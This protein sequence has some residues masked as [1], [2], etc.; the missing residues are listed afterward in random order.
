MLG[1]FS[2]TID[3]NIFTEVDKHHYRIEQNSYEVKL[4]QQDIQQL[5][6]RIEKLENEPS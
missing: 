1:W 6:R 3:M 4:Y 5:K 2:V